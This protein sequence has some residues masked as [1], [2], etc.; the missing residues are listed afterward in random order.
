MRREHRVTKASTARAATRHHVGQHSGAATLSRPVHM[1]MG[2]RR[3]VSRIAR[4]TRQTDPDPMRTP[5]SVPV[6]AGMW[7]LVGSRWNAHRMQRLA[8]T[9][10]RSVNTSTN[11]AGR[12]PE[13]IASVFGRR[14]RRVAAAG[15]GVSRARPAPVAT[16][17]PARPCHRRGSWG[18]QGQ[19]PGTVVGVSDG[20]VV[21]SPDVR[22]RPMASGCV[23][24]VGD[25]RPRLIDDLHE[26]TVSVSQRP[27]PRAFRPRRRAH[28]GRAVGPTIHRVG[29]RHTDHIRRARR[30]LPRL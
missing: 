18:Q 9:S 20:H 21:V 11:D 28:G 1:H 8:I 6:A 15:H 3:R 10:V 7:S 30:R 2:E 23:M 26:R 17:R 16:R 12:S 14:S 22:V 29:G 4:S 13:K 19:T 5:S 25:R 27:T 24:L